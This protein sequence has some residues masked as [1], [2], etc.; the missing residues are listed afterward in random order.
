MHESKH[1]VV[2][3]SREMGSYC[4]SANSL[5]RGFLPLVQALQTWTWTGGGGGGGGGVGG[6]GVG[7]CVCGGVV[8]CVVWGCV[9]VCVCVTGMELI[10]GRLDARGGWGVGGM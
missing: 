5:A 10:C 7:G 1:G 3:V 8:V 4:L 9:C 6:V 2:R